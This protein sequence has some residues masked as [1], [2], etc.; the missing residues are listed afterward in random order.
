VAAAAVGCGGSG[1]LQTADQEKAALED[2]AQFLKNLPAEGKKPP[3]RMG[4]FEPLE[5]MAPMASES[6]RNGKMVYLWGAGLADGSTAVVAYEKKAETDG[7]WALLQD[8]SVKQMTAAEFKAA[9]KAK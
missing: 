8:G 4:E 3:T 7:G 2:F 6:L 1:E 9:P 5:P